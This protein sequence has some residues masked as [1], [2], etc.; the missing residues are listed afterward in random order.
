VLAGSPLLELNADT[1]NRTFYVYDIYIPPSMQHYSLSARDILSLRGVI[2]HED[3]GLFFF[4]FSFSH[5]FWGLF[6]F[7][8]EFFCVTFMVWPLELIYLIL[9]FFSFAS[10]RGI[11]ETTSKMLSNSRRNWITFCWFSRHFFSQSRQTTTS[12]L[13]LS[14][15]LLWSGAGY[16]I[17]NANLAELDN[18]EIKKEEKKKKYF[19]FVYVFCFFFNAKWVRERKRENL[20]FFNNNFFLLLLLVFK[21]FIYLFIFCCALRRRVGMRKREVEVAK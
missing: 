12:A 8:G 20:F 19:F 21:Y 5:T 18:R 17:R 11:G 3:L 7:F 16:C 15:W 13:S 1:Q 9:F 14:L 10:S 6:S 2:Q 4:S